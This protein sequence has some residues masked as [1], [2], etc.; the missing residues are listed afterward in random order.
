MKKILFGC[1]CA[2]AL[3]AC[4]NNKSNTNSGESGPGTT[5]VQNVNGNQPDTSTGIR[6]NGQQPVDSTRKDSVPH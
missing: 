6:L 2:V 4:G 5:N 3:A 1:L